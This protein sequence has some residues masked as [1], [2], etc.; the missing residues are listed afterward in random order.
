ME[1]PAYFAI[2]FAIAFLVAYIYL[3]KL[4]PAKAALYFTILFSILYYG[5]GVYVLKI[6]D[7]SVYSSTGYICVFGTCSI[8]EVG[9][10]EFF[11]HMI[12]FFIA[13]KVALGSR[14][15]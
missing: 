13:A 8:V 15:K 10:V 2:K 14:L 5:V 12:V 4:G 11:V 7:L 3:A 1:V 6:P 9:V